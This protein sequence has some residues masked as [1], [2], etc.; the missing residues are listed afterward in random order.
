[1]LPKGTSKIRVFLTVNQAGLGLL[2]AHSGTQ[3]VHRAA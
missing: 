1:M 3:I 2:S